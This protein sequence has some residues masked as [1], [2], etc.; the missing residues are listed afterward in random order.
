MRYHFAHAGGGKPL[1]NGV[2]VAYGYAP[3]IHVVVGGRVFTSRPYRTR[4]TAM[5]AAHHVRARLVE[6]LFRVIGVGYGGKE[7]VARV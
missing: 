3:T 7:V 1:L 2:V 4:Q 5:R 6:P